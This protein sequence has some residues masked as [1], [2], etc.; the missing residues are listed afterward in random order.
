MSWCDRVLDDGTDREHWK[1]SRRPIV[2]A[3]D[4]ARLAKESSVESVLRSKLAV[5]SF[6]GNDHTESGNRWEPMM[7]AW[8]G[9]EANKALI[10]S[11]AEIG[12]AATPD[13]VSLQSVPRLAECKAKHGVIVNGPSLGEWRQ[14]SWQFEVVQEADELE[15]IWVELIDGDIRAGLDSEPKH[16]TIRRGDKKVQDTLAT[17]RPLATELLARLRAALEFE[18]ELESA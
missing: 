18:K 3:S 15:F 14:V 16:L 17:V 11:P 12:F 9:I 13:G 5:S 10:H 2:G 8:A 4:A 1:L 6:G 7:L